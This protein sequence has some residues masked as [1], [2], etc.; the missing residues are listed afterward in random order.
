MLQ[1]ACSLR[2]DPGRVINRAQHKGGMMT[3]DSAATSYEPR[4]A[5]VRDNLCAVE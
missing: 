1:N 4:L 3:H 2:G 5:A